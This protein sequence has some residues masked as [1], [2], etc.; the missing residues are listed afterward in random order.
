LAKTTHRA[1]ARVARGCAFILAV[2]LSGCATPQY[3]DVSV[4]KANIHFQI[5]RDWDQISSSSL[6]S[7][8]KA[9]GFDTSGTWIVGYDASPEPRTADYQT[10]D[11][12]RPFVFAHY[13][14]LSSTLSREMSYEMLRNMY[15]PVTSTARQ[16]AA[17]QGFPFTGFRQ[18]RDQLLSLGQGAQGVR[19]IYD[20]TFAGRAYTFDEDVATNADHT[21]I[22]LLVI[23]CT[24]TCYSSYQ[25]AID[26]VMSSVTVSGF[27]PA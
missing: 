2:S 21:V 16:N 19:E 15:L 8:L 7:Y 4:P 14:K 11:N 26:Y 18:I 3:T 22:F 27:T 5:P 10:S 6:A 9:R 1:A 13:G 20:Y 12:T 17:T 24:T 25:A 23:H